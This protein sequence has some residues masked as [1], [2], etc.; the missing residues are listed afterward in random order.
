[1]IERCICS[2][3]W[4]RW[5][6]TGSRGYKAQ[7]EIESRVLDMQ[8]RVG[9]YLHL[10]R[11]NLQP[12]SSL[13]FPNVATRPVPISRTLAGLSQG[14]QGKRKDLKTLTLS[15]SNKIAQPHSSVKPTGDK[16]QWQAQSLQTAF[17]YSVLNK[18]RN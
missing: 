16:P 14:E 3:D 18:S 17:E 5:R 1:M 12:S 6:P 11:C 15:F 9:I 13:G 2:L 4:E 10:K 8:E 7:L